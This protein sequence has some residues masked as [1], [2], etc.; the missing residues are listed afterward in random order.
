MNNYFVEEKMYSNT[1]ILIMSCDKNEWL[2][3]LF[4]EQ[5]AT[6]WSMCEYELFIVMER[7]ELEHNSIVSHVITFEENLTWCGRLLKALE[8]IETK[9]VL[10]FLDDYLIESP[11][12][13][14]MIKKYLQIMEKNDLYNIILTPVKN[15]RNYSCCEYD[16][17]EHRHRFGRYKTSLQCG[18]WKKDVLRYL[19]RKNENAWEFELFSNIRSFVL[20]DNF[21]AVKTIEDKPIDYDDGLFMVQGKVNKKEKKRLEKKFRK[22][23]DIGNMDEADVIVRDNIKFL[24]R[25]FR[26][27]KICGWYI[28]YR[29]KYLLFGEVTVIDR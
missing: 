29:I 2:M 18:L 23:I 21:Y 13:I 22:E 24:P 26:R 3:K 25:V 27:L 28:I 5:F 6:N 17:L 12:D 1:S 15:E 16:F 14:K 19:L 7:K 4:L 11:V 10:L 8:V 9:Y 20:K